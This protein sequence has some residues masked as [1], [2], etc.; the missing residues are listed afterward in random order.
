MYSAEISKKEVENTIVLLD[1]KEDEQLYNAFEKYLLTIHSLRR[2]CRDN[3]VKEADGS[4]SG[5]YMSR[6]SL[7]K[8]SE[9]VEIFS[10]ECEKWLGKNREHTLY[11]QVSG[12]YSSVREYLLIMEYYDS[13]FLTYVMVFAGDI[14]VRL[15]CLDPSDVLG[16]CLSKGR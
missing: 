11:N 2:L 13:R 1:K 15:Y 8:F 16:R 4:E 6:N 14:K 5:F 9:A 10:H 7:D 12:V 3:L